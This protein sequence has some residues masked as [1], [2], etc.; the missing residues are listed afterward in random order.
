MRRSAR[1]ASGGRLRGIPQPSGKVR[2][3]RVP[4]GPKPRV[5][6]LAAAGGGG[7]WRATVARFVPNGAVM[8]T[9]TTPVTTGHRACEMLQIILS[10]YRE[11]PCLSLTKPQMQRLWG[12]ESFVCEALVDA[13]VAA[14]VLRRTASGAYVAVRADR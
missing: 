11:M 3:R 13:L 12:L 1:E 7:G 5:R 4:W 6:P 8:M 10:E 2:R 9:P 14:S